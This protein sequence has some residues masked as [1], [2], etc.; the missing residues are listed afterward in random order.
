[1]S[2]Q[3]NLGTEQLKQGLA[4]RPEEAGSSC[5]N[6][7]QVKLT[8][9]LFFQTPQ[10][11]KENMHLDSESC[12][13]PSSCSQTATEHGAGE[14]NLPIYSSAFGRC[15]AGREVTFAEGHKVTA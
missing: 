12:T 13:E 3:T 4:V 10:A 7:P 8:W 5:L 11:D 6:C 14:I 15:S 9:D 1:M 2:F